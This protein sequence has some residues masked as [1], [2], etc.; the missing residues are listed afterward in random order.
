[1]IQIV[2]CIIDVETAAMTPISDRV[3]A[4]VA[5][6]LADRLRELHDTPGDDR[7]RIVLIVPRPGR[8]PRILG[9]SIP[10]TA[11]TEILATLDDQP[12]SSAEHTPDENAEDCPACDG[13]RDLPYPWICP[14]TDPD[15][16]EESQ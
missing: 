2:L 13:R 1:M 9:C 3:P 14:G 7:R 15:Q 11:V 6:R 8:D 4:A 16:P 12:T 10:A 5:T